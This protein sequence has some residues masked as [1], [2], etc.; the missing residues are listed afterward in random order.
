M[1]KEL[2]EVQTKI[3]SNSTTKKRKGKRKG[4]T[5]SGLD[6]DWGKEKVVS[7]GKLSWLG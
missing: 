6:W 3:A 5:T 1:M 4:E 2:E 7:A